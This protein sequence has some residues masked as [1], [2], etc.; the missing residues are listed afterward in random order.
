[1][2]RDPLAAFRPRHKWKGHRAGALSARGPAWT[3]ASPDQLL[4]LRFVSMA[5]DVEDDTSP[6]QA[7][8]AGQLAR[9]CGHSGCSPQ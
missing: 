3:V 9:V 2:G 5:L 7:P 1:M 8:E 6:A 4:G